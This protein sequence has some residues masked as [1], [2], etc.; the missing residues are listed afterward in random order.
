MPAQKLLC[1]RHTNLRRQANQFHVLFL[2]AAFLARAEL[3]RYFRLLTSLQTYYVGHLPCRRFVIFIYN[4]KYIVYSYNEAL[5]GIS[6]S[7][8]LNDRFVPSRIQ[9]RLG[10]QFG[11]IVISL[12]QCRH[13]FS[14]C[15]L[16]GWFW[17]S[18]L[19][20]AHQG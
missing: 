19:P 12:S 16:F 5:S 17:P 20:Q 7:P 6:G 14:A 8:C 11:R 10:S 4:S 15:R 2:A 1:P 9:A 18:S 3:R 13:M